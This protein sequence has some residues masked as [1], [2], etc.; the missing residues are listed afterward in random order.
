MFENEINNH[1]K[2]ILTPYY[3]FKIDIYCFNIQFQPFFINIWC[4]FV[5]LNLDLKIYTLEKDNFADLVHFCQKWA[6]LSLILIYMI[7]IHIWPLFTPICHFMSYL[8]LY[9]LFVPICSICPFMFNLSLYV[10][11]VPICSVCPYMFNLSLSVHFVP[12]SP[13]CPYMSYLSLYV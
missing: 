10:Q 2:L 11:I 12:I 4:N 7:K 6:K 8:S 13:I 9:V 3:Q 5:L 1:Q